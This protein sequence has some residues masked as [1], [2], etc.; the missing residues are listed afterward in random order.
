MAVAT[1]DRFFQ[2]VVAYLKRH[3][4]GGKLVELFAQIA[5]ADEGINTR[6]VVDERISASG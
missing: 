2:G 6:A 5:L 4:V 1:E 3:A